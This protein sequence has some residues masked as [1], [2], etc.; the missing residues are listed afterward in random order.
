MLII[1][2]LLLSSFSLSQ[3]GFDRVTN[4]FENGRAWEALLYRGSKLNYL[5]NM[6]ERIQ[7][8]DNKPPV[9]LDSACYNLLYKKRKALD[10][11]G[12]NLYDVEQ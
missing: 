2:L 6:L 9:Y 5:S 7:Y 1:T 10:E 8:F 4:G 12:P 11:D 3:T